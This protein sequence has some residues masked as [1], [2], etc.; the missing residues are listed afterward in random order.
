MA[1]GA[2]A[3][4]GAAAAALPHPSTVD[5]I[6]GTDSGQPVNDGLA[7]VLGLDATRRWLG[8]GEA[9][10]RHVSK[11]RVVEVVHA[12]AG[13]EAAGPLAA[14][15][16]DAASAQAEQML[17]GRRRLPACLRTLQDAGPSASGG[18]AADTASTSG[19]EAQ[20]CA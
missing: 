12:V 18:E 2:A 8:T 1:A 4:D 16:R 14:L 11:A 17:A 20:A 5:G 15:K 3:G 19:A 10:L 9:Y 13:A 7:R 6:T